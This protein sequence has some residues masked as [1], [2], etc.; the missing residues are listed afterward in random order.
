MKNVVTR[1][2]RIEAYARMEGPRGAGRDEKNLK[3]FSDRASLHSELAS[4]ASDGPMKLPSTKVNTRDTAMKP[5][6]SRGGNPREIAK[7]DLNHD[8]SNSPFMKSVRRVT[9]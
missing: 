3:V 7:D 1:K 5:Y 6:V 9:G 8:G 4:R 2:S